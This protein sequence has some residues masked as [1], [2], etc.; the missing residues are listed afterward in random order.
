MPHTRDELDIRYGQDMGQE[1]LLQELDKLPALFGGDGRSINAPLIVNSTSQAMSKRLVRNYVSK[2]LG[3]HGTE[4]RF[5]QTEVMKSS[6]IEGHIE[7]Q[8]AEELDGH[9]TVF[10]FDFSRSHGGSLALLRRAY[11]MRVLDEAQGWLVLQ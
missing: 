1:L 11:E 6:P 4:W 10:Y 5:I 2:I 3:Q 7:R 8:V 9:R